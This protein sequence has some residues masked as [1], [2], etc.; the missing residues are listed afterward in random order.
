[1]LIIIQMLEADIAIFIKKFTQKCDMQKTSSMPKKK[2]ENLDRWIW[3]LV[4]D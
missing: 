1:M 2:Y 4:S 3:G